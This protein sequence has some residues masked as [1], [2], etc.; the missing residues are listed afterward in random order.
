MIDSGSE[1]SLINEKIILQNQNLTKNIINVPKITIIG[2]NNKKLYEV[3]KML[4]TQIKFYNKVINVNLLIIPNIT[5]DLLMGCDI[6]NKNNCVIDYK[7]RKVIIEGIEIKFEN[8]LSI[9]HKK[10]NI[11]LCTEKNSELMVKENEYYVN[12]EKNENNYDIF[13]CNDEYY[14]II[15]ELVM[16]Y[17]DLITDET[18]VAENYVHKF[19][20]KDINN[21]KSKV[22]PIPYKY[23][24]KVKDEIHNLLKSGII[25]NSQSSFINPL[26]IVKKKSGEI[27]ICLDARNINKFTI[28]QYE[29]P[30]NIEAI[31]GRITE[32]SIFSKIDL[33]HSFWLIPLHK[34]CRKYTAFCV[35]GVVYEFNVVPFGLQSACA[36]LVRVLHKI[37]DKYDEF[38]L[39]FIDDILIHSYDPTQHLKHI[40]IVLNELD[41]AG[42]KINLNKCSF[43]KKIINYLGYIK[44][45]NAKMKKHV[46]FKKG[47][48]VL[49]KTL[50]VANARENKCAKLIL[51]YIGPYVIGNDNGVNSYTIIDP[52]TGIT[53][54]IFH[55]SQI[56]KYY[57]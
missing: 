43:Y 16:K 49:I 34:E 51:P 52:E 48:L 8:E 18:R 1:I 55:I 19:E 33:K 35:D 53:R 41:K 32:S 45:K 36:A 21:F 13:K 29:S 20:V 44:K 17:K 27:R 57:Q 15:K 2:A 10:L 39:H 47:D 9:D 54:G 24:D 28:P 23:K 30:M 26:V 12:D 7:E 14:D 11:N 50:R 22:Y 4:S 40:N 46:K 38:C 31:L 5:T 25:Q 37:L 56:Y 3:N 42:L 6:L